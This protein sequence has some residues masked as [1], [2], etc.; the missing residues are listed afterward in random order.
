[1]AAA[2][3]PHRMF[4]PPARSR[5]AYPIA[6]LVIMTGLAAL[7]SLAAKRQL[8]SALAASAA[9]SLERAHALFDVLR[10][11]TQA[12]LRSQCGVLVEDPRLKS[13][14]ST[15]G[16]DAATVADILTDLGRLRG[17][18]FL[19][20]L[21]PEG[22]VFAEAG[23][24]EL[25]GLDLSES[26]VVKKARAV[27]DEVVGAWVI[28]GKV[29]DLAIT[30]IQFNRTVLAYLVLGQAVDA[31]LVKAVSEGTGLAVAVIAGAEA[32]PASTNDDQL[33]AVFQT[34]VHDGGAAGARAVEIAGARYLTTTV[35][36]EGTSPSHP[37]LAVVRALAAEQQ[38]FKS[39]EWF[40]L[41]P[42]GL[43][44][45][46]IALAGQRSSYRASH[47]GRIDVS[48]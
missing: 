13:T 5:R 35:E 29:V 2:T 14:L 24:D 47:T 22:R 1:M 48:L 6:V 33:G 30:A 27:R 42:I 34:L 41:A 44:V 46:G 10:R 38:P 37:R 7:W 23:A 39:F 20:V 36:L 40:L 43:L 26:S 45:I 4:V 15:D 11:R 16:I 32:S 8:D 19:L 31:E 17:S 21:S 25:R 12:S 9:Q 18:G 3:T 28:G